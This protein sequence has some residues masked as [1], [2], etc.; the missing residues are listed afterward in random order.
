[1]RPW[2]PALACPS[3]PFMER[4]RCAVLAGE[5]RRARS[6]TAPVGARAWRRGRGARSGRAG[7]DLASRHEGFGIAAEYQRSNK[8]W[9]HLL[10][11][12]GERA[13]LLGGVGGP[14]L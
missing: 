9:Q 13:L 2:L 12:V 5:G 3:R 8:T 14:G 11:Q 10:G 6:P 1:M 7:G 4:V